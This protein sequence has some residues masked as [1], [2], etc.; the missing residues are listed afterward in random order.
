MNK[1]DFKIRAPPFSAGAE[2]KGADLREEGI[3]APSLRGAVRFRAK[4]GE[5]PQILNVRGF[6]LKLVILITLGTLREVKSIDRKVKFL[7]QRGGCP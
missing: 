2:P 5:N 1:G 4:R 6:S 7:S 3:R